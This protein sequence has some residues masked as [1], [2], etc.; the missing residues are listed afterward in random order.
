MVR[1]FERRHVRKQSTGE[2]YMR[3]WCLNL[4]G[5]TIRIHRFLK[6]DDLW[7]DHPFDFW[8]LTLWGGAKEL[9][10]DREPRYVLPFGVRRYKAEDVHCVTACEGMVTLI[11]A[12][13]RRREWGFV[14]DGVW[15]HWRDV[16]TV[17]TSWAGRNEG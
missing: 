12:A 16:D 10:P 15:R 7:H 1:V 17:N 6:P 11:V 9:F 13:P 3:R 8:A 5:W 4:F 14:I 2:M